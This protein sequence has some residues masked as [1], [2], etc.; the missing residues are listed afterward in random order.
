M[1]SQ[2]AICLLLLVAAGLL[3]RTLGKYRSEDLGLNTRGLLVFG[4]TPQRAQTTEET[5]HFYRTVLDR[6][7]ALPGVQGATMM[8]NRLGSGWSDNNSALLDGA[9]LRDKDGSE[10]L[11][12]SNSV[13]PDYFRILGI[14]VLQGRD[15]SAENMPG[16]PPVVVVNQ[17][18]VERFLPKTNPLG[19]K[20]NRDSTIVGVAKD[21]KYTSV[22][23]APTPMV[24][25]PA[26][27]T[28][29]AGDTMHV[30]LRYGGEALALLPTIARAVQEID[31]NVP[32]ERPATQAAE[33]AASYA[34]PTMFALLAE[35]FAGLAAF[36]LA[37][38]IYG[39]LAY[40]SH[41][42]TT[43]IG[44]HMALGAQP[45]QV[46][47]LIL[48]ESLLISAIGVA[49]GLPLALAGAR[50]LDS[51]L[52][53]LSAFDPVSFVLALAAM[54][55]VGSVAALLPAWRAA[56]VNPIV[57]LRYE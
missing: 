53:Q 13:G 2:V 15:I 14:P 55:L 9:D 44:M 26:F 6:L 54:A 47:W 57:A 28:L 27:Q 7:G 30:E 35:F 38:G 22:R 46:L 37:T 45:K 43:E 17:T 50:L 41:R 31:P 49:A 40:R 4:V 29:R 42:R 36:L 34:Q 3:L 8:E 16:S 51:M 39:T 48:R 12:R 1:S 24:Y 52:Y 21:N 10:A 20:L 25:Y 56:K 11:I 32:L 23:E 19:H 5:V 33:F 18:F